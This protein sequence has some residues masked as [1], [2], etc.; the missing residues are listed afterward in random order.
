[1]GPETGVGAVGT[2]ESG[3]TGSP[4]I[5]ALADSAGKVPSYQGMLLLR[6]TTLSPAIALAGMKLISKSVSSAAAF[7]IISR[8]DVNGSWQ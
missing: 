3:L 1:L 5:F 8:V 6:V 4:S 2:V 7:A